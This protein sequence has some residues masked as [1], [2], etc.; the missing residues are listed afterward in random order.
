MAVL[1]TLPG[2]CR[3]SCTTSR[4]RRRITVRRCPYPSPL[5]DGRPSP[6]GLPH[7]SI[8]SCTVL[9]PGQAL[10]AEAHARGPRVISRR[11]VINQHQRTTSAIQRAP[12]PPKAGLRAPRLIT[13]LVAHRPEV[14]RTRASSSIDTEKSNLT[15]GHAAKA[16]P[17][18]HS[19]QLDLNFSDNPP[20]ACRNASVPPSSGW[21]S[22]WTAWLQLRALP[23]GARGD[24]Q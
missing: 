3:S 5:R 21:I 19:Y 1:A 22:G 15:L 6:T 2:C 13:L 17:T 24:L 20:G 11:L 18:S 23:G 14:L 9:A 7:W 4:A 10:R 16:H 8:Q 12:A